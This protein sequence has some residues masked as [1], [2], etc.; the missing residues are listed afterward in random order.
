M[1]KVG[2]KVE[3]LN[4]D[5]IEGG[6]DLTNGKVYKIINIDEDGDISVIDDANDNLVILQRNFAG[7]KLAPAKNQRITA[8]EETVAKQGEEINELKMIVEQLR[9]PSTVVEEA[10][11]NVE[12]IIEF[13][14]KQYK[15]VEREARKGDVVILRG[16]KLP[17][18]F[19]KRMKYKVESNEQIMDSDGEM[20]CVYNP[21]AD[22]TPETVDVYE[23]IVEDKQDMPPSEWPTD[24]PFEKSPN[25]LRAEI[26]EKAKRFVEK[27]GEGFAFDGEENVI[28]ATN[29]KKTINDKYVAL[30]GLSQ[31]N[32]S[33]VFNEH[34][35]KAIAL[36][37]A[38]GLDVS[39]F[40]QAV[41]PSEHVIGHVV[42][43]EDG[44]EQEVKQ[45]SYN[46]DLYR[47]INDTNAI[48]GG[49]E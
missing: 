40:E 20:Q 19:T 48:Y 6:Y 38:L 31:C 7:I 33:D 21:A 36:G 42:V 2:D 10:L 45:L 5:V 39:E 29:L 34:I 49:V 16:D 32:P 15:K 43:R 37:R 35:G 27:H 44:Y 1:F 24:Y 30:I 12:N 25:Q 8:L 28:V 14:G 9:K 26:I 46:R 11:A 23:L 4:K 17:R 22:R 18:W 47:I 3:I 13:E 41:Q